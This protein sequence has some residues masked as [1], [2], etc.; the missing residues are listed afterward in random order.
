MFFIAS[1]MTYFFYFEKMRVLSEAREMEHHTRLI[2]AKLTATAKQNKSQSM[3]LCIIFMQ[4]S[5]AV[6]FHPMGKTLHSLY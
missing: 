6:S 2:D 1:V 5:A 4:M 3:T